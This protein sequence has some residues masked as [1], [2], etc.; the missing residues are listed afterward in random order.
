MADLYKVNILKAPKGTKI[1][2]YIKQLYRDAN[3]DNELEE[4]KDK[5]FRLTYKFGLDQL[6]LMHD[7]VTLEEGIGSMSVAFMKTFNNF[8]P[9][10]EGASFINYYKRAIHSQVICDQLGKYRN[11]EEAKEIFNKVK[12]TMWSLDEPTEGKDGDSGTRGDIMPSGFNIDE[13]V[14]YNI[15][16][17][18][19][20][21]IVE[22][23]LAKVDKR[24]DP[25]LNLVF[26]DYINGHI[27][28]G[29]NKREYLSEKYGLT[30]MQVKGFVYRQRKKLRLKL[31][32][33]GYYE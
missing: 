33:E 21:E 16:V 12:G 19:I 20:L 15:L 32:E 5:I 1:N 29:N 8:D 26:M 24:K 27:Y 22:E 9:E 23:N 17:K 14:Y 10:A 7:R 4:A 11:T 31:I 30:E 25:K 18:R 28:G 6:K 13:E 2:D 3:T